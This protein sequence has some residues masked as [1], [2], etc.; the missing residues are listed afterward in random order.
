M[1]RK[2]KSGVVGRWNIVDL[3]FLA[4]PGVAVDFFRALDSKTRESKSV[5]PA[6]EG[7]RE[8]DAVGRPDALL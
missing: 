2:L 7:A 8:E 1:G 3:D 5:A 6:M 4:D